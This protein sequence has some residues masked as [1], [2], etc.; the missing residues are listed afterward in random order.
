MPITAE[1]SP[2]AVTLK[3]EPPPPPEPWS[4]SLFAPRLAMILAGVPRA[5]VSGVKLALQ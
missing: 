1:P 5:N 3:A 2:V 4:S